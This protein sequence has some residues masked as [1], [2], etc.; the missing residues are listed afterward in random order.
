MSDWT[1]DKD[2]RLDAFLEAND[3]EVPQA[4]VGERERIRH[5]LRQ[6]PVWVWN[7]SSMGS[8]FAGIAAA[9]IVWMALPVGQG[10][11]TEEDWWDSAEAEVLLDEEP[12][13]EWAMLIQSVD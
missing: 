5:R 1:P 6:R 8:A 9:L 7:W 2:R 13:R 3:P 4:P 12:A 10:R 11:V